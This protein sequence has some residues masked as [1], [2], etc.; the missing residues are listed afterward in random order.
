MTRSRTCQPSGFR[1]IP[2]VRQ[3]SQP[4]LRSI[5]RPEARRWGFPGRWAHPVREGRQSRQ[6]SRGYEYRDGPVKCCTG[7]SDVDFP[8]RRDLGDFCDQRHRL[9]RE[10]SVAA[11]RKNDP[12]GLAADFEAHRALRSHPRRDVSHLLA[13]ELTPPCWIFRVASLLDAASPASTMRLGKRDGTAP[14]PE[15]PTAGSTPTSI[16]PRV[17]RA[18]N[19]PAL[20]SRSPRRG[21]R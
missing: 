8:F 6:E 15:R 3:R 9:N 17:K 18:S 21:S 5:Q 1:S 13:V 19:A 14:A 16:S 2:T 7:L 10:W 4:S 11:T 20:R 12:D